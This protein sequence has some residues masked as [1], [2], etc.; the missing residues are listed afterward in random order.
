MAAWNATATAAAMEHTLVSRFAQAVERGPDAVALEVADTLVTY[1]ELAGQASRIARRL[2]AMGVG[3]GSMVGILCERSA[4]LVAAAYGVLMAGAAYVPLESGQPAERLAFM[5]RETGMQTILCRGRCDARLRQP[6]VAVVDLDELLAGAEEALDVALPEVRP[7]DLAYVI[8]TSG[9]TGRPK[10]VANAHRGP[11]NLCW[12]MQDRFGLE[13]GDVA[14][15]KAP[16]GFDMSVQ[17]LFWPLQSGARLVVA[18]PGGHR[19]PEYLVETVRSSGV[20]TATFVPLLLREFLGRPDAGS[21]TS[22][23]RIICGGEAMTPELR[24]RC[25]AVL[26]AAEPHNFYGPTEAAVWVT[27]DRCRPDDRGPSVPI[28]APMAN[29]SV[30]ILDGR[31][32]PLPVGIPGELYIGGVQVAAGYVNR[33]D[34]TAERFV[35]DPFDPPG[36]LYRTGDVARWLPDG[37][38]EYL[39]RLDRQVKFRGQRIELGEIEV[40]LAGHATVLEAAVVVRDDSAGDPS[41]VAYLVPR[42]GEAIDITGIRHHL[43][44]RLPESM[45]PSRFVLLEAVP[46]TANG[47]LDEAALPAP[48]PVDAGAGVGDTVEPRTALEREIAAMWTEVLA[49][50]CVGAET[51]FFD[52]GGHSLKLMQLASRMEQAFG[53]RMALARL[54]DAPTVAAQATL[55]SDALIDESEPDDEVLA[56]ALAEMD[57]ER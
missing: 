3:R 2:V 24:E 17:E 15:L 46:L 44:E 39:G 19:D 8:Y 22:L 48:D 16:F 51:D 38:L 32:Q 5:V 10:G 29:T 1:R 52:I 33:D 25:F 28:G 40:T 45:V 31:R 34:L 37:R 4:Q 42:P 30:H 57:L 7:D 12:W 13:P 27:A 53:L 56:A 55:V 36:R 47:K 21:C 35:T 6:A 26:P 18:A 9:S 11:V 50:D 54:F 49:V 43:R 20:T 23:R 41:L 14:L